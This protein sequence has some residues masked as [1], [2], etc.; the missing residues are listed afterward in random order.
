MNEYQVGRFLWPTVYCCMLI[1]AA[2]AMANNT[3]EK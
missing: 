1:L 3:R 2:V